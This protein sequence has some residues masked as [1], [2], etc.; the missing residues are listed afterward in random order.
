MTARRD[1]YPLFAGGGQ[2]GFTGHQTPSALV[3]QGGVT[4]PR[5]RAQRTPGKSMMLQALDCCFAAGE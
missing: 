1:F 2:P 3:V 5:E 4:L